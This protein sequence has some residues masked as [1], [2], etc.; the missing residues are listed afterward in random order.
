MTETVSEKAIR[1]VSAGDRS[2]W[3]PLMNPPGAIGR[4]QELFSTAAG[5]LT[6]GF[7][8]RQPDTWPFTRTYDEVSLILEGDAD[9]LTDDNRTLTLGPGDVL[10]TPKGTSGT[11]VIRQKI[12]KFWVIYDG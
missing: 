9:I 3:T 4:E 5:S 2:G 8:E 12:V 11:S 7:W 6:T 1:V 10:I